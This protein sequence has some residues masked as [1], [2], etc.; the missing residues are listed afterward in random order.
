MTGPVHMDR[1]RHGGRFE[2]IRFEAM[3]I[4]TQEAPEKEA[5]ADAQGAVAAPLLLSAD[6]V[7]TVLSC[8]VRHVRRLIDSGHMPRPIKLGALLRWRKIDI[9]RWVE[10]GCPQ[11]RKC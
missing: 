10:G 11:P 3:M 8:S 9:E 6:Q 5:T 7:A 2:S 1:R 4:L